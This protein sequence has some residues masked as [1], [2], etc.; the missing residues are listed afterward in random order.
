MPH[1]SDYIVSKPITD[2]ASDDSVI[3]PTFIPSQEEPSTSRFLKR[4]A[5]MQKIIPS[6]ISS[7]STCY[8]YSGPSSEMQFSD[9]RKELEA[10]LLD[11]NTSLQPL[12][13]HK[14][15]RNVFLKYN[16]P[17]PS[18]APV[19]RLFSF[20]GMVDTPRRKCLTDTNF[21]KL[22]LLKANNAR[23]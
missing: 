19:E 15:V 16:T 3:D 8:F 21:E 2:F 18:S 17:I 22:V 12:D 20:A 4:K 5:A 14:V 7:F 10:Y 9:R 6:K 13:Q 23:N 1:F 11:A